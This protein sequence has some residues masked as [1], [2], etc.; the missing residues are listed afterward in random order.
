MILEVYECGR[1]EGQFFFR[2]DHCAAQELDCFVVAGDV[3]APF[4]RDI[5]ECDAHK[6]VVDVVP[7]EVSISV[8]CKYFENSVV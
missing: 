5:F 4:R 7:A 6:Q 2:P 3:F 8:S 1:Y